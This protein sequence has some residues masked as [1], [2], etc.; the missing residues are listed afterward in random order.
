MTFEEWKQARGVKYGE[1]ANIELVD[2]L[3]ELFLL[4]NAVTATF[5]LITAGRVTSPY[6]SAAVVESYVI[7]R[8]N[9]ALRDVF[10]SSLLSEAANS[11]DM[12]LDFTALAGPITEKDQDV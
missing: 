9:D 6:A 2:I 11:S 12:S 4:E 5:G 1:S 8:V 10:R 7:D 3:S